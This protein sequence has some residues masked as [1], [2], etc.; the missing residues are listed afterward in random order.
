MS[1]IVERRK[2]CALRVKVLKTPSATPEPSPVA[3]SVSPVVKGSRKSEAIIEKY[4]KSTLIIQTKNTSPIS[5][6]ECTL[7]TD[8]IIEI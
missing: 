4:K 8:H 2:E 1:T 7:T 5:V 3:R 6:A